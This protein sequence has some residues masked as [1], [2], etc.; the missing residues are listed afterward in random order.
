MNISITVLLASSMAS[1]QEPFPHIALYRSHSVTTCVM[2][3]SSS[4]GDNE[5]MAYVCNK[6][7]IDTWPNARNIC[8]PLHITIGLLEQK[9]LSLDEFVFKSGKSFRS[10]F[11]TSYIRDGVPTIMT[12]SRKVKLK[13]KV[14]A[15]LVNA[16]GAKICTVLDLYFVRS[17]Q[18]KV[19]ITHSRIHFFL[20]KKLDFQLSCS[21]GCCAS[22]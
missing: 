20:I 3:T 7:G 5:T 14:C 17:S 21:F 6:H 15:R 22:L 10:F 8:L 13:N 1:I 12:F 16:I 11:S 4:P 19:F 18:K 9:I 2:T